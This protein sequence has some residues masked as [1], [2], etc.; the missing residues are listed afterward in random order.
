M[1]KKLMFAGF[2]VLSV[3][4]ISDVDCYADKRSFVWTYE[5]ATMLKDRME[6]E[7]YSTTEIPDVGD[8]STSFWKWQVELEYGITEK[9]DVAVYEMFKQK[10]GVLAAFEYEGFKVRT[11]YKLFEKNQLPVDILLYA[12]LE[13][14][15]DLSKPAVLE[16]KIILARTEGPWYFAYN[17]IFEQELE[18][19]SA[20]V[21]SYSSGAAYELDNW[22]KVGFELKGNYSSG[23]QYFGPVISI[24]VPMK[25]FLNSGLVK[26]LHAGSTEVQSRTIFGVLF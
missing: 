1:L 19:T 12:E 14:G 21:H 6:V 24:T 22:L 10:A 18:S 5:Y 7:V 8:M 2:A 3:I 11:R 23:K 15:I 4:G 16:G 17:Q 25:F 13:R 9:F 26:G 20:T